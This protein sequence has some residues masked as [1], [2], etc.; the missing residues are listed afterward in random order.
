MVGTNVSNFASAYV[1]VAVVGRALGSAAVGAYTLGFQTGRQAVGAVTYVSNLV[2]FPAFSKIQD[3]PDR[4]RRVYLRSVR[5]V[6]AISVPAGLGLAVVSREFVTVVYGS[7]WSAAASVV[8]II[9]VMAVVVSVSAPMGEVL[10]AAGLPNVFFRLS[11]LQTALVSVGVIA[12]YRYG[13]AAVAAAQAVGVTITGLVLARSVS[14][15]LAI[16]LREWGRTLVPS[17]LSGIL[18]AAG[19]LATKLALG[20][21]ID[22]ARPAPLVLLTVEATVLYLGIFRITSRERCDEFFAELGKLVGT[23][24]LR[25]RVAT[26]RRSLTGSRS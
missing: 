26:V 24:K 22:T 8:A 13:I 15:I 11:L 3:D 14:R 2:I 7:R 21:H 1:D 17:G 19:V 18:M 20:R 9:A 4:F 5:F 23:S 16:D 10:K 12:L 25:P 6:S